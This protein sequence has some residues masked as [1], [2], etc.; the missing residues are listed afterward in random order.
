MQ[1]SSKFILIKCILN[2]N[3]AVKA[4]IMYAHLYICIVCIC[5][6]ICIYVCM[7]ICIYVCMYVC[8]YVCVY[9]C[10]LELGGFASSNANL[11]WGK[12]KFLVR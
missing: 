7:Y 6:Y 4:F 2:K 5:M 10:R 1:S 12:C 9:V 8:M 11:F 3:I